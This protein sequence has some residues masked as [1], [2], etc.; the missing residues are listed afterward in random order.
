MPL[1]GVMAWPSETLLGW[2]G[3]LCRD[4]PTCDWVPRAAPISSPVPFAPPIA[5]R[6]L[7]P[8]CVAWKS[9]LYGVVNWR[10][11]AQ[12]SRLETS[13]PPVE[14]RTTWNESGTSMSSDGSPGVPP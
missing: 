4:A 9:G 5:K 7:M 14:G 11:S 10:R 12:K 6:T 2:V 13:E 3:L 1:F 8:M